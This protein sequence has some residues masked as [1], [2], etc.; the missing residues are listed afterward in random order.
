M[1]QMYEVIAARRRYPV[2]GEQVDAC[3]RMTD[4]GTKEVFYRVK[5]ATVP[6]TMYTVRYLRVIGRLICSCPAGLGT[7]CWHRRAATVKE[8][9]FKAD[10]RAQYE[11][12]RHAIE[13]SAEYRLEV[14]ESTQEQAQQSYLEALAELARG[15]GKEK[16]T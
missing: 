14:A 9:L 10:L 12:A 6:G 7:T 13:S 3:E 5:S 15:Q 8:R 1:S 16:L 4:P 2:T 11:A